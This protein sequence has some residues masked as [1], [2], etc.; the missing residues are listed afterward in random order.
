MI[1]QEAFR[2]VHPCWD[3]AEALGKLIATEVVLS[4]WYF[5]A[6]ALESTMELTFGFPTSELRVPEPVSEPFSASDHSPS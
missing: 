6:Q 2:R 1:C 5:K 3:F 4:L